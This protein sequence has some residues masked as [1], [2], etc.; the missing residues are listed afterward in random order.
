MKYG[1][2]CI[3]EDCFAWTQPSRY[4]NGCTALEQIPADCYACAFYK[5]KGQ[6]LDDRLQQ[7]E[8]MKKDDDYK[9]LCESYGIKIP[10]HR[11]RTQ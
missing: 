11:L 4:K 7:I 9:A 10:K 1:K 5:S 2:N 3:R 6:M 8:R